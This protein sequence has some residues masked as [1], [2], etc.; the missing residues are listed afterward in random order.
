LLIKI[1]IGGINEVFTRDIKTAN[2]LKGGIIGLITGFVIGILV[3]KY[4]LFY[5]LGFVVIVVLSV[6]GAI[7]GIFS[8]KEKTSESKK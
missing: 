1:I 8:V 2:R 7:V 6:L 3:Q 5:S 4:T